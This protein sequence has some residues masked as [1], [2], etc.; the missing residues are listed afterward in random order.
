[1]STRSAESRSNSPEGEAGKRASKKRK[2]LSCYACRNRKMKCDRV[3]PVCGRCQKTGRADQCTYDPR[4]LEDLPMHDGHPDGGHAVGLALANHS[5]HGFSPDTFPSDSVAWKLRT[6][7]RRLELLER[8]LVKF[9]GAKDPLAPARFDDFDAE[10]AEPEF[11][12]AM[13]F[14]GKAF[15]TQ[16]MGTTSPMSVLGQFDELQAFTRE[17]MAIDSSMARIRCDFKAFRNRRKMT[18]KEQ[19]PL[20]QGKDADIV[21]LVPSKAACDLHVQLYFRTFENAH[22]ILH[23][24]TFWKDYRAFWDHRPEDEVPVSFA[25]TLVLIVATTKCLFSDHETLFLGD[26]SVEREAASHLIDVCDTWLS[27]QSRKHL[28]LELFQLLCLSLLAK[29][30]NC[31][32]MKQDWV[33]TGEVLRLAIASGLHRNSS[34]LAGG[35]VSEFDKEM[36][37]RLWATTAE[38]ELQSSL[39]SGLQ[40]A[41]SGLYFDTQP[42]TNLPDEALTPEME[43]APAGRPLDAFTTSSYLTHS[44]QSLPLRVHLN[45]LLNNPTANLQYSDIL[46]YDNQITSILSSLPTWSDPRAPIPT[47]ILSLQLHQYLLILHMPYAKLASTNPRYTYSFTAAI[48]ATSSILTLYTTLNTASLPAPSFFRNDIFRAAITLSQI[49]YH[50]SAFSPQSSSPAPLPPPSTDTPILTT[51]GP[52]PSSTPLRIPYLPTGNL[53][54]STLCTTSTSL[55]STATSLFEHKVMR[56]GTGYMEY[57]ILCAASSLMPCSPL[58][59]SHPTSL[60]TPSFTSTSHHPPSLRLEEIRQRGSKAI[61][62][63]TRLCFRVLALQRD[64]SAD[65]AEKLRSTM[66]TA[67]SPEVG[68]RD[69][70]GEV[71]GGG[72]LKGADGLAEALVDFAKQGQGQQGGQMGMGG[73]GGGGGAWE[74]LQD[75]QVDMS[76][77]TFP[78]FWAWDMGGDF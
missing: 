32:K 17:A 42:P 13:M 8:K 30:V 46:H 57:W 27:R 69:V 11:K 43:Q 47:A 18:L 53:L 50:N 59:P 37:R 66:A 38:L 4:L 9:E 51:P 36:R 78:D 44:A 64:P 26:S 73:G 74:G 10:E 45:Q 67:G 68:K 60:P 48:T 75:M 33:N 40:S 29:K 63:V 41:L 23:E 12:E 76:G 20:I 14:R 28:T 61:D 55:L 15:K 6:Q 5:T 21:A 34:Q 71:L 58:P 16:F 49:V 24:P 62:G 72:G 39:D 19:K 77:W 56:L 22:R 1:M 25:T 70:L 7:E 2:V 65:F 31:V 35:R 52:P 3:Y 54:L